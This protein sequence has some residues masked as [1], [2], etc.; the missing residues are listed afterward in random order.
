MNETLGSISRDTWRW[1]AFEALSEAEMR[2]ERSGKIARTPW[3]DFLDRYGTMS[4]HEAE[5]FHC[6]SRISS[7]SQVNLALP[8][9]RICQIRTWMDGEAYVPTAG[10]IDD[11]ESE[12]IG[13][14]KTD[15]DDGL[16]RVVTDTEV[17]SCLAVELYVC[18][19]GMVYRVRNRRLWLERRLSSEDAKR[20]T[21]YL[22][23]DRPR[24]HPEVR[25][26][27]LY[28][29]F[30]WRYMALQGPRGYRRMLIELG[31]RISRVERL[32]QAAGLDTTT[33]L[34]F[35]DVAIESF[36]GFDGIETTLLA[37]TAAT[38]SGG[39]GDGDAVP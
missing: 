28:V 25:Y 38:C 17:D 18:V 26:L 12:R 21:D 36:L 23:L 9:D 30:P 3:S 20:M 7:A 19:Q 1:S 37:T 24:C 32:L 10:A 22:H 16:Q 5:L 14:T 13:F 2:A 4:I 11:Q 8:E 27:I 29:G 35:Y 34:D 39:D 6:N 15:L 33:S 31:K